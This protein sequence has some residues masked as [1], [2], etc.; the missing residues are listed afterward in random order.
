MEE[1]SHTSRSCPHCGET[2][3]VRI[4]KLAGGV[5]CPHCQGEVWFEQRRPSNLGRKISW[6]F[7]LSLLLAAGGYYA[8]NRTLI[9]A[10]LGDGKAQFE[11]GQRYLTNFTELSDQTNALRW[12]ERSAWAK[13]G[14]GIL[15]A[16]RL[17]LDASVTKRDK[18]RAYK[19]FGLAEQHHDEY[20]VARCEMA[21]LHL[22]GMEPQVNHEAAFELLQEAVER[23]DSA[24]AKYE[25]G[26]LY[27]AGLGTK[28]DQ[29]RALELYSSNADHHPGCAYEAA[30]SYQGRD[31]CSPNGFEASSGG[32]NVHNQSPARAP[33]ADQ[34]IRDSA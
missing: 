24:D 34:A 28:R 9:H 18:A 23:S 19:Y 33:I 29:A 32:Y 6:I 22:S 3:R 15:A 21:M 4:E 14:P 8:F 27:D 16:G 31:G 7:L 26:K 13:Y 30:R 2:F 10:H 11:M 5:A 25:L 17:N 12:I 20:A 1:E